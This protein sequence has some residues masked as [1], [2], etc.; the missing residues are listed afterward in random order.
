MPPFI[1]IIILEELNLI[2]L[3]I[4]TFEKGKQTK[5]KQ[6]K[7]DIVFVSFSLLSYLC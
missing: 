4:F 7:L 5:S 3:T 6:Y 2:I 1:I